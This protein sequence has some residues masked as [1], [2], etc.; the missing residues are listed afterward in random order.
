MRFQRCINPDCRRPYQV[1]EFGGRSSGNA[2]S[3]ICPH[4]GHAETVWTD[5][6]FLVH[7]MT[8]E[9]EAQFTASHPDAA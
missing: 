3:I 1:N 2:E 8:P 4:C 7:A 6:V 9:E 5:S